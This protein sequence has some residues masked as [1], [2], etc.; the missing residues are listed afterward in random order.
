VLMISQQANLM[1][2]EGDGNAAL[3]ECFE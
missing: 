1:L 2:R 3:T